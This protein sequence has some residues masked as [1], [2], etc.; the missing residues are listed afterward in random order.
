MQ[1]FMPIISTTWEGEAGEPQVPVGNLAKPCLKIQG[2][3]IKLSM[4]FLGS[5]PSTTPLPK[6]KK[7]K[8]RTEGL[9]P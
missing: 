5:T 9:A 1:W 7:S 8:E 4:K 6:K 3:G 2:W